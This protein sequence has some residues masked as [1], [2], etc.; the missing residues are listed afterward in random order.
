MINKEDIATK[1]VKKMTK[2]IKAEICSVLINQDINDKRVKT[3]D[4]ILFSLILISILTLILETDKM[5]GARLENTFYLFEMVMIFIFSI[6]YTLRIWCCTCD[7]RYSRPILGRIKYAF[8]P[9]MLIDLLAIAPFY[10]PIMSDNFLFL[11][12]FRLTRIFFRLLKLTKHSPGINNLISAI[13]KTKRELGL[14]FVIFMIVV[15]ATASIMYIAEKDLQPEAFSSI[16]QSLYWTIIT[17]T[18]VGYGDIY[19]ISSAGKII[20][21]MSGVIGIIIFAVPTAILSSALVVE[22]KHKRHK[23]FCSNCKHDLT[24]I[25]SYKYFN[26]SF[27]KEKGIYCPLCREKMIDSSIM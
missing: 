24:D 5:I 16:P 4:I 21:A 25:L 3:F 9:L 12:I 18:T 14:S 6:E 8:T 11:R 10:M 17:F 23:I 1:R 2:T 27:D 20:A 22:F 13:N 15:V 26:S 7:E 19:P